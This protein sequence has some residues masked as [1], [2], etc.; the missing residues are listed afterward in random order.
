[1]ALLCTLLPKVKELPEE[2]EDRGVIEHLLCAWLSSAFFTFF[3]FS[4]NLPY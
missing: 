2:E 1:M 3:I 4:L